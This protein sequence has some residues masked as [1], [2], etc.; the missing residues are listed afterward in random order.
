MKKEYKETVTQKE[1]P[2]PSIRKTSREER[3]N[4]IAKTL[5]KK[6]V[7]ETGIVHDFPTHASEKSVVT[8]SQPPT[9]TSI[10]MQTWPIEI[11]TNAKVTKFLCKLI[12][13]N[14]RCHHRQIFM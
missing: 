9:R 11:G 6:T 10:T 13:N 8:F 12:H 1:N 7:P 14:K 5:D 4:S 2:S 3:K